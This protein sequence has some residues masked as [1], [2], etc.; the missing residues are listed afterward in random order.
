[1]NR[2][3]LAQDVDGFSKMGTSFFEGNLNRRRLSQDIDGFSKMG[4]VFLREI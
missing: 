2:R 4:T 3:R 1:M